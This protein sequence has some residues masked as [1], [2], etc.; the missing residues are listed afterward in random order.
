[1]IVLKWGE[2][3]PIETKALLA[4]GFVLFVLTLI[5]NIF[6]DLIVDKAVKSGK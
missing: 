4:S 5:I 3:T 6:A 2:A 1:M